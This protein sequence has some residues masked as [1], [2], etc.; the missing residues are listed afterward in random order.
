[1]GPLGL[2]GDAGWEPGGR[3]Q[4]EQRWKE[5][6]QLD[7]KCSRLQGSR[8]RHKVDPQNPQNLETILERVKGRAVRSEA[9]KTLEVQREKYLLYPRAESSGIIHPFN[10]NRS[11]ALFP[12]ICSHVCVGFWQQ[13]SECYLPSLWGRKRRLKEQQLSHLPNDSELEAHMFKGIWLN[14]Q[15]QLDALPWMGKLQGI[16]SITGLEDRKDI[17]EKYSSDLEFSYSDLSSWRMRM[18]QM[19][20]I[21]NCDHQVCLKKVLGTLWVT[22]FL[23]RR[24]GYQQ[25]PWRTRMVCSQSEDKPETLSVWDL[26]SPGGQKF[27]LYSI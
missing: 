17:W 14:S 19:Y 3:S 23:K 9:W 10:S 15:Y 25:P 5:S 18:E 1:M 12:G 16:L 2:N 21:W 13:P 24:K 20:S 22:S 4:T 8:L 11:Q 27:I 6:S 26:F 7:D